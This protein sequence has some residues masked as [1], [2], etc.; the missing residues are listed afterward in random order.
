[1][2]GAWL[3]DAMSYPNTNQS[4]MW[5]L[6]TR[7]TRTRSS[8]LPSPYRE[9]G[10]KV[11]EFQNTM[12][13]SH[14]MY[15]FEYNDT[16]YL[17]G[18]ILLSRIQLSPEVAMFLLDPARDQESIRFLLD[19]CF[20]NLVGQFALL[21]GTSVC[22]TRKH[23]CH[24]Y[25]HLTCLEEED[26]KPK[27]VHLSWNTVGTIEEPFD[28]KYELIFEAFGNAQLVRGLNILAQSLLL[29]LSGDDAVRV[30]IAPALRHK[31]LRAQGKKVQDVEV[32]M[33]ILPR[34]EVTSTAADP[35]HF[36]ISTEMDTMMRVTYNPH[37]EKRLVTSETFRSRVTTYGQAALN[38]LF[39]RKN[40]SK[41][42][43]AWSHSSEDR[44]ESLLVWKRGIH[45]SF[46]LR[47][48]DRMAEHLIKGITQEIFTPR[49]RATGTMAKMMKMVEAFNS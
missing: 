13:S 22:A 42:T 17:T 47:S 12:Y 9:M 10:L 21:K 2:L 32:V 1:V 16:A 14:W 5:L 43:I 7:Y 26:R 15:L 31:D 46:A 30:E 24:N 35:E 8:G 3:Y 34:L 33:A 36:T 23:I 25:Q 4:L 29:S 37:G 40:A 39:P 20:P 48:D 38:S 19:H 41:I 49:S 28:T 11:V 45:W 18:T 27:V 44:R 6:K